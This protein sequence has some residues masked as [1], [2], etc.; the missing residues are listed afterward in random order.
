MEAYIVDGVILGFFGDQTQAV[1]ERELELME[2]MDSILY[3][4]FE[5]ALAETKSEFQITINDVL[6]ESKYEIKEDG[7]M[8]YTAIRSDN[9]SFQFYKFLVDL[10]DVDNCELSD[11]IN[12]AR[13]VT[14]WLLEA[15]ESRI[16][17]I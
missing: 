3:R 6:I 14:L 1:I 2:A 12:E 10:S 4:H 13:T 17:E 8:L 9:K 7:R 11:D 5:L 15:H 16:P